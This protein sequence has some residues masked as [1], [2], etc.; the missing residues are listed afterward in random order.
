MMKALYYLLV[1][2]LIFFRGIVIEAAKKSRPKGDITKDQIQSSTLGS[3]YEHTPEL[4]GNLEKSRRKTN[5]PPRE[6]QKEID[7]DVSFK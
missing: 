3:N 5:S 6:F 2:A 4:P 1:L 7:C